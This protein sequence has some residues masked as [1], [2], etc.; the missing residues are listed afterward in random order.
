MYYKPNKIIKWNS[1][2]KLNL[3][4]TCSALFGHFSHCGGF[5]GNCIF[6]C[7]F[8]RWSSLLPT[9]KMWNGH[10]LIYE[11][12]W[13]P[14]QEGYT[15]TLCT[16]YCDTKNN[17]YY[18]ITVLPYTVLQRAMCLQWSACVLHTPTLCTTH[19]KIENI[20]LGFSVFESVVQLR[21]WGAI[22]A[23]SV[24]IECE[25][26][27]AFLDL[28]LKL[29]DPTCWM[30]TWPDKAVL[31]SRPCNLSLLSLQRDPIT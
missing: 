2:E 1:V 10:Q 31:C 13:L 26:D 8:E 16:I 7:C 3:T 19:C 28:I 5:Q 23:V 9:V 24:Y 22:S 11:E 30:S 4:N 14:G 21:Y 17:V 20:L 27:L 29:W 6:P 18:C 12:D 15:F 25:L